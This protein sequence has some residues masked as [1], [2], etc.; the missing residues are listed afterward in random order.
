MEVL[1][2][3]RRRYILIQVDYDPE[4]FQDPL[5]WDWD[6]M[7]DSDVETPIDV[8]DG[9]LY[10]RYSAYMDDLAQKKLLNVSLTLEQFRASALYDPFPA[11][12]SLDIEDL[13]DPE[14][15]GAGEEQSE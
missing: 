1:M 3:A 12:S 11:E 15:F 13:R 10:V 9:G 6:G 5:K 4:R 8:T 14:D 7:I 2:R